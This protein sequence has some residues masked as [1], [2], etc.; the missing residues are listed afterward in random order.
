MKGKKI[1]LMYNVGSDF[2]HNRIN[3]SHYL[4]ELGYDVT[5]ILPNDG[6]AEQIEAYGIKVV[7]YQLNRNSGNLLDIIKVIR[8]LKQHFRENN[9]DVLHT[10]RSQ[11]NILGSFAARKSGIKTL[12]CHVTGLGIIFSSSGIK[13][14]ILRSINIAL[15]WNAFRYAKSVIVQNP[16]DY[17]DLLKRIPYLKSKL[18]LIKG[19]GIDAN[20]F[21]PLSVGDTEKEKL[22]VNFGIKDDSFVISFVARLLWHKGI[23]ELVE[24][25]KI[26][27][28]SYPN[29][30]FLIVGD[31]D[32]DNPNSVTQS[33]V[34]QYEGNYGIQFL[35]ERKD[36]KEILSI[37]SLYA[38]PSFYREGIP[39]S[40]LE[41]MSMHLPIVTTENPG[42]NLT[43]DEGVNG[44]LVPVKDEIL[45]AEAITFFIKNP[46]KLKLFGDAS[47]GKLE[48]EFIDQIIFKQ[49]E[50]L[51]H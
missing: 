46:D 30:V 21:N 9:Y 7:S 37:T 20:L 44:K 41:A 4:Q 17:N 47:R 13:N 15:Y 51:Y 39:R 16:D 2:L 36:I 1:A 5:A 11:P 45:L 49:F 23:K 24:A 19:S 14:Y 31:K 35:G 42:C 22:K 6:Y 26:L 27:H 29:V 10:L 18:V 38:F 12:V 3:Y 33:F 50:E 32:D 40:V 25:A 28:K 48:N 34:D 8:F 43:V